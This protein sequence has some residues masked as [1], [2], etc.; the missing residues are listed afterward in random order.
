MLT[1]ARKERLFEKYAWVVPS[2]MGLF[3]FFSSVAV[4]IS[5]GIF[6]GAEGMIQSLTGGPFSQLSPGLQNYIY[7]LIR[8]FGFTGLGLG[9][10]L[11]VVSAT[12]YKKGER[13]AWYVMWI[14]PVTFLID[15]LNDFS[16]TAY[17]DDMSIIILAIFVVGLLLPYRKFFGPKA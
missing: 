13:W 1:G 4:L 8:V 3:F 15:M 2:A 5:P 17:V 14:M 7:W 11:T 6:T 9:G 12:A 16:A 10:F